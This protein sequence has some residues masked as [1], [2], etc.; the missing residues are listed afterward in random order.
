MAVNGQECREGEGLSPRQ[1]PGGGVGATLGSPGSVS[2]G[3]V[4]RTAVRKTALALLQQF[5][6]HE[7]V[8]ENA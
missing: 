1:E 2:A 5:L 8:P 6:G 4:F 7:D 3:V